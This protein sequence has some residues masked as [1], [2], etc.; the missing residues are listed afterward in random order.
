MNLILS[1]LLNK[2]IH[3]N[4][5]DHKSIFESLSTLLF[6]PDLTDEEIGNR[7]TNRPFVFQVICGSGW[8]HALQVP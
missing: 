8:Q 4:F 5:S 3:K 2:L 6:N 1:D 7:I